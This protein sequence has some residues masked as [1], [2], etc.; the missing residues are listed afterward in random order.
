MIREF[1]TGLGEQC[2]ICIGFSD[3]SGK[4][5]AG[6]VYRPLTSPTTYAI[7]AV[8]GMFRFTE[9]RLNSVHP[10]VKGLLTSYDYY[11]SWRIIDNIYLIII[12]FISID[13]SLITIYYFIN[14]CL[15]PDIS[16]GGISPFIASLIAELKYERYDYIIL[17][18]TYHITL[19]HL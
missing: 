16:N 2:S 13:N 1:S 19:I 10:P 14:C 7:G 11:L 3:E 15:R 9:S 6:I 8:D 4:P 17:F 5:V 12:T 18:I